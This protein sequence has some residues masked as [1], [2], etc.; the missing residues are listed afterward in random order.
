MNNN[1]LWLILLIVNFIGITLSYKFLKNTGLY[2]WIAMA[3]VIANIQVMKTIEVMGFVTTLGNIIYGTSYL[4]T[5]ILNEKYGKKAAQK[6]VYIGIFTLITVTAIMQI[7]LQFTAHATDT[8][9]GAFQ[10]IFGFL[11]RIA[12]A[13]VIAYV[14]SQTHDVWVFD[15]L[16]KRMPNKLWLRNNVSTIISQFLDTVIFTFIAFWGVMPTHI[17]LEIFFVTYIMKFVVAALDTP[18]IYFAKKIHTDETI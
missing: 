17:V 1:I 15:K 14:I 18:F 5:D 13:S 4:A 11:P 3:A 10:T 16:K 9:D 8:A 2:V 7:C 12:L 6:G